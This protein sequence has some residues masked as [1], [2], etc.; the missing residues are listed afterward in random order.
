[1]PLE[2]KLTQQ[3]AN[4]APVLL[5]VDDDAAVRN[6]LKFSLELEGFAVRLYAGAR[7][8]LNEPSLPSIGCLLIDY[9]LPDMTGL[10]L[11]SELRGCGV[12]LP[13]FLI[14]GHPSVAVRQR[15]AE[16]GV[17]IVEK[18]LLGNGLLETIGGAVGVPRL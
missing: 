6:S 17:L 14:T 4:P 18:P 13:A 2:F 12:T 16:A 1:M 7:E 8:L 5:V 9:Y 15:A 3:L 11:L 10:E